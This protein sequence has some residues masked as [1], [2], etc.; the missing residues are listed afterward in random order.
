MS[1][2]QNKVQ[3]ETKKNKKE[4]RFFLRGTPLHK[5]KITPIDEEYESL[6]QIHKQY[7]Q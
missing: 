1:K 7:I 6:K 5:G 3:H 4:L 2:Q